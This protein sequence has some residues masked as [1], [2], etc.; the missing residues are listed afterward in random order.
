MAKDYVIDGHGRRL[1]PVSLDDL[2][3]GSKDVDLKPYAKKTEVKKDI[4]KATDDLEVEISKEYIDN[5]DLE[6]ALADYVKE[7]DVE[8]VVQEKVDAAIEDLDIEK[9]ID[10]EEIAEKIEELALDSYAKKADVEAL[11]SDYN[12]FKEGIT[13]GMETVAES[14][15]SHAAQLQEIEDA[16]KD[17]YAT[18]VELGEVS[19][20]VGNLEDTVD[21]LDTDLTALREEFDAEVQ[22]VA[23]E[24]ESLTSRLDEFTPDE[25][26]T[27]GT[28]EK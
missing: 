7:S 3:D 12:T 25:E 9:Y 20:A 13:E 19:D 21:T 27:E 23:S 8:G 6:A 18:K 14:L 22:G 4:N 24:F 11:E 15:E 1:V 16:L 5:E 2:V 26:G 10:E 17:D 28:L